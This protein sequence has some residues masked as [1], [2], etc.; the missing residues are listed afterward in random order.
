MKPHYQTYGGR[1]H[2]HSRCALVTGRVL[3]ASGRVISH[4]DIS[5]SMPTTGAEM[6]LPLVHVSAVALVDYG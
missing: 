2:L 6:P 3:P 4:M 1:Q 5:A